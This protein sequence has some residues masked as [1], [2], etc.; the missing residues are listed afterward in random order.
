MHNRT[1][2]L[3]FAAGVGAALLAQSSDVG[4]QLPD[5]PIRIVVPY[6]AGGTSDVG[7]RLVAGKVAEGGGLNV[8]VENKA[9]GGGV[10]AAM[11]VKEAAPDGTTLFLADL[12]SFGINVSLMSSLPYDPTRD[13]KPITT[14]FSFP[15]VLAVPA[16]LEASSVAELIAL[17]KKK[18]DGLAF[19]SQGPGSGG[20]LLAEMLAKTSGANLVHVP[21]RGVAAVVVDL[22]AGRVSML[23]GSYLATKGQV[24]AKA[25]RIL[26]V[27]SKQRLAVLPDTPTMAELGYPEVDLDVWFGLV[28]PAATP[29]PVVQALHARFSS[30]MNSPDIVGRLNSQGVNVVTNTPAGFAA[31]IKS[32]IARVAP[33]VKASGAR[34]N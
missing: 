33:V 10:P 14:L 2:A 31:L 7:T 28:A 3:V 1:I 6:V 15:S 27:T 9:G 17:S 23:Y 11:S 21:Y 22:V 18:P 24:E 4:A 34:V 16:A 29:D 12:G 19:G 25:L 32:D 13:F 26:A 5:R 20:H 8:V 30:A